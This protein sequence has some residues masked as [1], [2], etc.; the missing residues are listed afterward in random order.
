MPFLFFPYI[1]LYFLFIIPMKFD[2]N[3]RCETNDHLDGYFGVFGTPQMLF[4][5][6]TR[7]VSDPGQ[8]C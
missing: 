6:F 8:F 7:I 1:P 2:P 5:G 3:L 4:A